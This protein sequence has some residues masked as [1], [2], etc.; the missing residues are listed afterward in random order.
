MTTAAENTK[1]KKCCSCRSGSCLRCVCGK[2]ST[3]CVD[4]ISPL[5]RNVSTDPTVFVSSSSQQPSVIPTDPDFNPSTTDILSS[6]SNYNR[7]TVRHIPRSCRA[8][9]SRILA[10]T[11]SNVVTKNDTNSWLL[12]LY[13]P[14]FCLGLPPDSPRSSNSSSSAVIKRQLIEFEKV[15]SAAALY[16]VAM[17]NSKPRRRKSH[18]SSDVAKGVLRKLDDGDVKGAVRLVSSDDSIAPQDEETIA[19]LKSRHPP[20]P[21]NRRDFAEPAASEPPLLFCPADIEKAIR[22]FPKGSAGGISGLRP[23][24]LLNSINGV[25]VASGGKVLSS[26]CQ[27]TNRLVAGDMTVPNEVRPIFFGANLTALRKKC[28]GLRPIAVGETLRRLV[29]K[30]ISKAVINKAKNILQP[31][32]LGVGVRGGIEAAVHAA[33]ICV[34]TSTSPIVMA[35]LDFTNAFNTIRRDSVS[36]AVATFMPEMSSFF[37]A[38]YEESTVL[39]FG[40]TSLSSE[41]GLQQGDPLAPLYFC[42]ALHNNLSSLSSKVRI[43]YLDDVTLMDEASVVADDIQ[44]FRNSCVDIGLVLNTSKCELTQIN[45]KNSAILDQFKELLPGMKHVDAADSELLGAP[46][47][48]SATERHLRLLYERLSTMTSRL[49]DLDS[50]SGLFLLKNCFSMPKMLYTLRACPTFQHES[51]LAAIDN[52]IC[53]A[54]SAIINVRLNSHAAKQALLPTGLGGLGMSSSS[55]ICSSAFL[56]SYNSS[57]DLVSKI[58][59]AIRIHPSVEAAESHWRVLREATLPANITRQ[60]SWS[61]PV[62]MRARERIILG[63]DVTAKIRLHGCSAPGSGAW[64]SAIP[65]P[66]LGLHL[67]NDQLRIAVCLRLG[68]PVSLPHTCVCGAVADVNGSHAL[69]CRKVCGRHTRHAMLNNVVAK[70]LRSAS[71][72]CQL[73]PAGLCREDGK[74]PDGVTITPWRLGKSLA[75]DATVIHRLAPSYTAAAVEAGSTVAAIAESRKRSKYQSL[76]HDFHFEPLAIES[77]GG[78]GPS[79][80]NFLSKLASLKKARTGDCNEGRYLRQ[81]ISIALQVGNAACIQE[82]HSTFRAFY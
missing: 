48:V 43:G 40:E 64:L 49:E 73:E 52:A 4:C 34:S 29:A 75:W 50:H 41:E 57:R 82:T 39:K 38:T 55:A 9:F 59:G 80:C 11:L 79:S 6:L 15:T 33:H 22:S 24:H 36:E 25:T 20:R 42:L 61:D 8:L 17:R 78:I 67:N 30:C 54:L 21:L 31:V 32:Q 69:S 18:L 56:S 77:L 7:P 37:R 65:S 19:Y 60:R 44:R 14:L 12:L 47:G 70:S 27:L 45:F 46:I 74:R 62:F 2:S 26:L 1:N 3:P 81:Q 68:C 58:L 23:Q 13:L 16:D 5:C 72:P 28:G 53:G 66:S 71:I 10:S 51:A 35:K 63:S 76:S